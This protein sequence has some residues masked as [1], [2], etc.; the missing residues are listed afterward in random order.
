MA[1]FRP[2]KLT[3]T[4]PTILETD[5]VIYIEGQAHEPTTLTPIFNH[6]F[7]VPSTSLEFS[8]FGG[9][10]TRHSQFRSN[11]L[12]REIAGTNRTVRSSLSVVDQT[13]LDCG[14]MQA[15][16]VFTPDFD[17]TR[18]VTSPDY[19]SNT[20]SGTSQ[21]LKIYGTDGRYISLI[22][23]VADTD[24][25]MV[26]FNQN[27]ATLAFMGAMASENT[28][29]TAARIQSVNLS[30]GTVSAHYGGGANNNPSSQGSFQIVDYGSTHVH[31]LRVVSNPSAASL[32]EHRTFDKA[33]NA[34][35]V[36]GTT[37]MFARSTPPGI[38]TTR[39]VQTSGTERIAYVPESNA[40]ASGNLFGFRTVQFNTA[41]PEADATFSIVAPTGAGAQPGVSLLENYSL[42][43]WVTENGNDVYIHVAP[44]E[45]TRS[46]VATQALFYIHT[47]K[48]TKAAPTVIEYLG[49]TQT[50]EAS[51]PRAFIPADSGFLNVVVPSMSGTD[52]YYWSQGTERYVRGSSSSVI[53]TQIGTDQTG[54]IWMVERNDNN[55]G[56][57][58]IVSQT[59]AN[60]VTV[61]F[62]DPTLVFSGAVINTNLLVSSY[63]F[64]GGRLAS[65][66][67]LQIDSASATFAD[68]TQI[69]TVTTLSNGD[70]SVPIKLTGAGYVR[71]IANISI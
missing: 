8:L 47:Y 19:Y 14:R 56:K 7:G 53:A 37:T 30:T 38:F 64:S 26:C 29:G 45:Q 42:K 36:R 40:S 12:W 61:N 24:Q 62:Q 18:F 17:P 70:L 50:G 69:K 9:V 65:N 1:A 13:T 44:M 31:F 21:S 59:I 51:R 25:T 63:N 27:G 32:I 10:N 20:T 43:S 11:T 52:F 23:A 28:T 68:D 33:S 3:Y 57:L 67:T 71:V 2:I 15:K 39:S 41:T 54:R 49:S 34:S 55:D 22:S 35:V 16:V 6:V 48:T 66:V 60:T 4:P 5:D 58:H 46:L